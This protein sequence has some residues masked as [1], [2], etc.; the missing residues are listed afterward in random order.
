M[1]LPLK[2]PKPDEP[3]TFTM[4]MNAGLIYLGRETGR[5][6]T[7]PDGWSHWEVTPNRETDMFGNV[8][9]EWTPKPV[10]R[11]RYD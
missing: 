6:I 3:K 9:R 1:P 7:D 8:V 5:I 4:T 11:F 10:V 2:D